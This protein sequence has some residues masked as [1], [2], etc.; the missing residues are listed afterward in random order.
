MCQCRRLK[1]KH[2]IYPK[3]LGC[4]NLEEGS[5]SWNEDSEDDFDDFVVHQLIGGFR[6]FIQQPDAYIYLV[7]GRG[8]I[9]LR[10]RDVA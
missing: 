5:Q 7:V 2:D 4:S 8:W 9:R 6:I 1:Q 3:V 10:C